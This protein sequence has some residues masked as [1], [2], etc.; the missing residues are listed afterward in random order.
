MKFY[1][2]AIRKPISGSISSPYWAIK[3][4]RLSIHVYIWLFQCSII[5][6]IAMGGSCNSSPSRLIGRN[7]T[8]ASYSLFYWVAV[9]EETMRVIKGQVIGVIGRIIGRT[10]PSLKWIV[11]FFFYRDS[12]LVRHTQRISTRKKKKEGFTTAKDWQG[13][14][15]TCFNIF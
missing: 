7:T 1:L 2:L 13:I 11:F 10:P 8:C 12:H 15:L 4:F 14:E 3:R 6:V 9:Y 5:E